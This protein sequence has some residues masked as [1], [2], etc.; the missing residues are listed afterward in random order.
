MIDVFRSDARTLA[1][2]G[3]QPFG[4]E[5]Q[6]STRSS[7]DDR[8]SA[9]DVPIELG[10]WFGDPERVDLSRGKRKVW[11]VPA[12]CTLEA[13]GSPA[14]QHDARD[15]WI[16]EWLPPERQTRAVGAV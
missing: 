14:R 5:P 6:G 4:V 16:Q 2:P 15:A 9:I 12:R 13:D 3:L 10:S 7:R 1:E 11:Y 8:P